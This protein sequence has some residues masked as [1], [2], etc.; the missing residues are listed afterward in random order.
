M[1][2]CLECIE[3]VQQH[4]RAVLFAVT[5]KGRSRGSR[6]LTLVD[7]NRGACAQSAC[8]RPSSRCFDLEI[9]VECGSRWKIQRRAL[10]LSRQGI[11]LQDFCPFATLAGSRRSAKR[12]NGNLRQNGRAANVTAKSSSLQPNRP[13][14]QLITT[15]F[16]MR[17]CSL[18]NRFFVRHFS[19]GF[20]P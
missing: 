8:G 6:A 12:P 10:F 7:Q 17:C 2:C 13:F 16:A 3:D 11:Q 14:R 18:W 1:R 15:N 9:V 19:A 20:Q 5:P 4:D